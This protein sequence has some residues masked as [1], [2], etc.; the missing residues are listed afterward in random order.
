MHLRASSPEHLQHSRI[1]H[2][3][4]NCVPSLTKSLPDVQNRLQTSSAL[5]KA[6]TIERSGG[7]AVGHR[8][9]ANKKNSKEIARGTRRNGN[10]P[11][12][13]RLPIQIQ[14]TFRTQPN[15]H[16][17][18]ARKISGDW[19]LKCLATIYTNKKARE[20]GRLPA[21]AVL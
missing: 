15:Q 5:P 19:D 7:V 14:I 21:L 12:A 20:P 1:P 9:R 8:T 16:V 11:A 13:H 4:H 18:Q 17:S 2:V 3:I 10:V 6:K